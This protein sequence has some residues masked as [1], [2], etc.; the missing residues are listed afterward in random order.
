[1][2][3]DINRVMNDGRHRCQRCTILIEDKHPNVKYCD[4]CYLE[5]K[6]ERARNYT[7]TVKKQQ[8]QIDELETQILS[9]LR[10][11]K[12]ILLEGK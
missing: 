6:K 12:K 5:A 11:I 3:P 4:E 2:E 9:E 7:K 8:V 1:M 10:E